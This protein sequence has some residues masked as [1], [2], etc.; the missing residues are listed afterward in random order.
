MRT[1]AFWG[2]FSDYFKALFQ[3]GLTDAK[4]IETIIPESSHDTIEKVV[5]FIYTGTIEIS[6]ETVEEIVRLADYLGVPKILELCMRFMTENLND[7]N[8]LEFKVLSEIY[9]LGT[10]SN[11]VQDYILPRMSALVRHLDTVYGPV[12]VLRQL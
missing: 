11:S 10:L 6:E 7:S 9:P 1:G 3:H 5:T 12:D 4:V 2:A 8:C